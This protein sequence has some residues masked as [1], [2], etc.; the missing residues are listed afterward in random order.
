MTRI[1]GRA[2]HKSGRMNKLEAA[3]AR[4]LE[5]RRAAGEID[6]FIFESLKL[7]LADKTF[8]TPDFAVM[9]SDGQI[10]IHEVKGFWEDDA[11]VK[12]KVAAEKFPFKFKAIR[13]V[14]SQW[15]VEEI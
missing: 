8:Y 2:R 10:E 14:K 5:E 13:R 11:R 7:K 12:I 6:W 15:E 3:Y 4:T 1:Y 9:L